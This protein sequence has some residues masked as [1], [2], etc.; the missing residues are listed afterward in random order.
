ME[1][2][3][4]ILVLDFG[5]QYSRLIARRVRE[6]QVFS[7]ILP[8]NTPVEKIK[9]LAPKGIILSGGPSSVYG[10]GAPR[11]QK[12][13]FELGLPILG[14][15]YGMQLTTLILGGAVVP[16]ERREY[17]R[18]V[19]KITDTQSLFK[20]LP[21]SIEV[22]MSHGDHVDQVPPGFK[23]I[24]STDNAPVAAMVDEERQIYG[25]QFHPEVAHTPLGFDILRNFVYTTCKCRPSWTPGSFITQEIAEI[26]KAVGDRKVLCAL[27]G[28]VDSTV[29][30]ILIHRAIGDNLVCVFVDNGL[31]RKD[32]AIN[33][34]A[35]L[36]EKFQLNLVTVDAT[37]RFLSKL[38]DVTD[39]EEKRKIIGH[40]FISVFEEEA[41]KL[42]EVDF[43]V[44]GTL[45]PDVI[46]SISEHGPAAKIKSHHNVGGLPEHLR[47]KLLE[48]FRLLFKDEVRL[49]G[50][51][52]GLPE[53]I[54]WRQPFPGPGLAVRIIGP[55]TREKLSVLRE[56]D[57]I[58][59][60]EIKQA[61]YYRKLW[62]SFAVLTDTKS[63]GVMG[64]ERTY[65]YVVAVRA[66]TSEDAMTADWARLP[67]DLLDRISRRIINEVSGVNRVVY[68]ITSK[69][70]GTIEWE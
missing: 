69:P 29:A 52:L 65:D 5:S 33:V 66:V 6:T 15:C 70:P 36:K 61:G 55:V 27:S 37:E 24:A 41:A 63:V 12:E 58:V 64:D 1:S 9:E 28:G 18:T 59:T 10:E 40:E 54:I 57:W 49:I 35:L 39:P 4:K 32:E 23:V 45:Y 34:S 53:E 2:L 43:L 20:D 68:D 11:C 44:Q 50:G 26:R 19:L 67:Y 46:E 22:W 30:A 21:S 17:G 3:E 51:E 48:P 62:Q 8:Y 56:A 14:I 42:G 7:E 25:I 38:E 13:V 60:D 31:L 47:F 16:A